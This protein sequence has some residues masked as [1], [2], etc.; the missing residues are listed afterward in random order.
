MFG[1]VILQL[2]P[3]RFQEVQKPKA[4]R[5]DMSIVASLECA[6]LKNAKTALCVFSEMPFHRSLI[7]LHLVIEAPLFGDW[8]IGLRQ[9]ENIIARLPFV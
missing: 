2:S 6:F 4:R 5:Q 7:L 1:T 8:W 3:I 9:S